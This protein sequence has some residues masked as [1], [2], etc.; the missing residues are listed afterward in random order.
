MAGMKGLPGCFLVFLILVLTAGISAC[1][2]GSPEPLSKGE[3]GT[4]RVVVTGVEVSQDGQTVEFITVQTEDG[5]EL[6]LTLGEEIDLMNWS[7]QHLQ[8][9]IGL[10]ENF[11]FS[12][13]LEYETTDEGTIAIGLLE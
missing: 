10:G 5:E 13:G 1:G 4:A 8:L 9:H 3:E 7:P 11:G 12:I 6:T 2:G